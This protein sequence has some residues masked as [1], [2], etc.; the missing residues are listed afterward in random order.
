[1]KRLLTLGCLLLAQSSLA[2]DRVML[3]AASA[4][5]LA[6]VAGVS[7]SLASD[8]IALR[9]QRGRLTSVEEL[10]GLPGITQ[11][12][13]T[14]L[15]EKTSIE[16]VLPEAATKVYNNVEE[17]L[18]SFSNE[19]TVQQ[20][21]AWTSDYANTNPQMVDRWLRASR[22]F[23]ALPEVT[24]SYTLKDG[25]D[26]GFDY[27]AVD[28]GAAVL[29]DQEVLPILSDA[30]ADQDA[31]Y[32]VTAKWELDKLVMSSERIRVLSEAQD[33]VKLRDDILENVTELYFDRRRVQVE[34]LLKPTTDIRKQVDQELK[35]MELTANIDAL[36]GGAFSGALPL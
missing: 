14:A 31:T 11:A 6:G 23:A 25:W 1:M 13:L 35:L 26:Q 28:G 24:L 3:N 7:P 30:G 4:D 36:T 27:L 15:R 33:V 34:Q 10:R 12:S 5:Q 16:M 22:T 18:A 20:V 29:P 21:Q 8:I 32:K 17:V 19:P 2:S 9:T